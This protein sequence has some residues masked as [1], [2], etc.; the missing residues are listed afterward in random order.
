MTGYKQ[1]N[2]YNPLNLQSVTL[3][4]SNIWTGNVNAPSYGISFVSYPR[5]PIG[6]STTAF[7]FS[8]TYNNQNGT[9]RIIVYLATNG[10]QNY[11]VDSG[12]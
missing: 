11:L 12:N 8:N 6:T 2:T 4:G 5:L 7:N 9:E 1:G 3:G 10:C